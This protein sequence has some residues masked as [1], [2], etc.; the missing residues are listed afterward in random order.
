M[1]TRIIS[2]LEQAKKSTITL[3]ELEGVANT[4][5]TYEE[6]AST[7]QTLLDE[8]FITSVK[9]HGTNWKGLPNSFRIQKGRVKQPII[10]EIQEMQFKVHPTIEL[11][12][13]FSASKKKWMEEKPL[14]VMIDQYLQK[15][16]LP[17]TFTNSSE[18]SYELMQDEK[19][20]DEKGGKAILE[21]INLF[22]KLKIMNSPDPL[23]FAVN[24]NKLLLNQRAY[25]HLI[26][27]NKATY[28]GLLDSLS[29]TNFT[30]LIYGSG[31]KIASGL[32][33]LSKQLGLTDKEEQ[34]E[35]Y[36]FGDLDYEGISIYYHLYEKYNVKLA[37]GFYEAMLR[38][39]FY[40]GKENQTR[41][42][43]A[44]HHFVHYFGKEE[45]EKI[46][47]MF[48]EN[49]YYPQESLAKEELHIIWRDAL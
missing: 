12:A 30:T 36:Y 15:N 24:P 47:A 16:G 39:P 20:I 29:T 37:Q 23:M 4:L 35:I 5:D 32:N 22:D 38:K 8:G 9:S 17:T 42:E 33:Q 14:I 41:N 48:Q 26:V 13:Y 19:W 34:H 46:A 18:R 3:S 40:K 31:W 1:K 28:S 25:K 45:Q 27:E 43:V 11:R 10:E 7:I 6:F 44:V 21:K 49:G 2:I